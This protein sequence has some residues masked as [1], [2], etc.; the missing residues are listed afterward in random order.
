VEQRVT[1]PSV[2]E[3]DVP[4]IPVAQPRLRHQLIAKGR[5]GRPFVHAY[6][7]SARV[8]PWKNAVQ[9]YFARHQPREPWAGPVRLSVQAFFP[10][11]QRLLKPGSPAGAVW[12]TAKPDMDNLLKAIKDALTWQADRGRGLWLDDAQVCSYGPTGK[13]YVALGAEPGVRIRA[14]RL[15][16]DNQC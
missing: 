10:R 8:G 12:F 9:L 15:E 3:W 6:T 5:G 16:E 2:I 7:P 11:P 14:E 1:T 4:G 13:F